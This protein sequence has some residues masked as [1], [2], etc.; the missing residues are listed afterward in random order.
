M[1]IK[2][3]VII[4]LFAA[5]IAVSTFIN[6]PIPPISFTLQTLMI[7]LIGFLLK[8]MDAF[9]AVIVYLAVGFIGVPVFTSGGGIQAFFSPTGGF[10]FSFP[11]VALGISFFKSKDKRV[12]FDLQ[13][14]IIFGIILV[15][16]FGIIGFIMITDL[17]FMETLVV[18]I[19]YYIWDVIKLIFAYVI[20]YVMPNNVIKMHLS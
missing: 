20:Y 19:P 8:P 18:F 6:I 3:M 1:T 2:R 15:Y 10:L 12:F 4:S 13:V 17:T 7:V 9:L 11:F 16:V 5:L 14:L